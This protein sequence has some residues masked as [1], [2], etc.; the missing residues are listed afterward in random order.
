[1]RLPPWFT[2]A[3]DASKVRNQGTIPFECPLVPRIRAPRP[4]TLDQD[5]PIPPANFDSRAI[6]AYRW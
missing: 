3:T 1:L 2:A 6:W 4:R 5:T